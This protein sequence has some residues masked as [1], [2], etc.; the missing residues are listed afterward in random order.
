LLTVIGLDGQ[1]ATYADIHVALCSRFNACAWNAADNNTAEAAAV[2][3]IFFI[4]FV[5]LYLLFKAIAV[6][7]LLDNK[8][9]R[10]LMFSIQ[11]GNR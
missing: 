11:S 3:K 9:E 7:L 1:S 4:I 2:I 10:L 6:P 5:V 8:K